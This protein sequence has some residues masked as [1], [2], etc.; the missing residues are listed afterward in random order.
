MDRRT[1][2]VAMAGGL[3]AAPL[4]AEAQPAGKVYRIGLLGITPPTSSTLQR[5]SE[6]FLQALR[7]HGFIEGQNVIIERR[8]SEGREDRHTTF[9]AEFLQMKVDLIVTTS[10]AAA[11]AAKQATTTIPIVMLAVANPERQGLVTSLAHPGGNVT[12]MSNQL[13]GDFSSKMF[14]FLKE[15]VPR[16]SKVAILWNPDNL[17]SAIS[18]RD[19][20]VPAAHALRLALVSLEVRGPAD[21]DHALSTVFSERPDALWV[22]LIVA[23]PFRARLLEFA[24]KNRL[25]T[26]AQSSVWPEAGGLM[27]YGPDSADLYRRGAAQVAKILKGAKPAD[28]PVEQPTKF[29]LVI[30]LKTAKALGLTIPQSLLQRAD[31]VIE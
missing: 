15:S 23:L 4:A 31:Q 6:A 25:P 14:Q 8:Y 1:F 29:E 10:S 22:H 13:G 11:R 3:L 26:I 16:L 27:S 18:F 19:G 2:V 12:G 7:D 24:A 20:E 17:G 28:L 21:L 9:V 5:P 30:N